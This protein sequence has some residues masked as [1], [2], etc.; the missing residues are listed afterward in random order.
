MHISNPKERK[1]FRDR[2]EKD[3]NSLKFTKLGKLFILDRLIHAEG[4]EKYLQTKNY[5]AEIHKITKGNQ[6]T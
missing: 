6:N 1:W 2:I 3:E 5:T 4:L